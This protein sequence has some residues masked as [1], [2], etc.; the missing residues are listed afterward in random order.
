MSAKSH[1][2]GSARRSSAGT[3]EQKERLILALQ[4]RDAALAKFEAY[5]VPIVNDRRR[6][7]IPIHQD[8]T[9]TIVQHDLNRSGSK[10]HLLVIRDGSAHLSDEKT[11]NPKVLELEWTDT[12]EHN[13]K[14]FHQGDWVDAILKFSPDPTTFE[15]ILKNLND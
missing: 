10:T 5:S 1:K 11:R 15:D 14:L 7:Q 2:P 12:R 6:I 3:Q 13:L 9:L 8:L 4:I